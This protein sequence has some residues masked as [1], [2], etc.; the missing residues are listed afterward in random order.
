MKKIVSISLLF[1]FLVFSANTVFAQYENTS[2]KKREGAVKKRPGKKKE[3]IFF[4]GAMLGAGF[5]NTSAYVDV[6]PVI[7]IE[8]VKNLQFGLRFNYTYESREIWNGFNYE[9]LNLHHY[10]ASILGR[11]ILYK[12][13]F[14]QVEYE[15]LSYDNVWFQETSPGFWQKYETRIPVYTLFVG[16]GYFQRFGN[17]FASFALLFPVYESQSFYLIPTVRI[18]F[19]GFF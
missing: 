6:A 18:A 16:G 1:G 12:G 14:A 5:S 11:Y 17:G 3:R 15:Y 4:A 7:G 8:P 2:G 19:G 13:L 9:R 10:G